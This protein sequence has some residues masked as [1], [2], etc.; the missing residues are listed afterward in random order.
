M[1]AGRVEGHH[2]PSLR[3]NSPVPFVYMVRCADGT[4]Y[5]GY[6]KDV[7]SRV[8]VHNAGKGAKYTRSRLPV[9]LVFTE[10]FESAAAALSREHQLKRWTRAKK[11]ALIAGDGAE[12]KRL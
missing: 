6:A 9:T 4:L 5:T 2:P 12:L 10:A 8:D 11:E 1:A 7:A 3:H